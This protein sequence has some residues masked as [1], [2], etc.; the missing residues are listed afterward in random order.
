VKNLPRK[1]VRLI[2]EK[3]MCFCFN[4]VKMVFLFCGRRV[5]V[6]V[7]ITIATVHI[8]KVMKIFKRKGGSGSFPDI[9]IK[10]MP[11]KL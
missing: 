6:F 2:N 5:T 7:K 9:S 11:R 3:K 8:I 4:F 10:I 1:N